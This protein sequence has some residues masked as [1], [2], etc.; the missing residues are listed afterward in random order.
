MDFESVLKSIK[1]SFSPRKTIDFDEEDI[2]VDIEPLTSKEETIVLESCKDVDDME[3]IETLKRHTLACAIKKINDLDIDTD[4]I[5]YEEGKSKSKFLY[6]IDYLAR[7][8]STVIDVLFE[9][10]THMQKDIEQRVKATAKYERILLSEIVPVEEEEKGE[11]R[12]TVENTSEGLTEV[13][14]LKEQ[15]DKEQQDE[16]VRM[17]DSEETAREKV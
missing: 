8:P 9:A 4:E 16:E 11:F 15:V 7:W 6:M 10:F 3:Y 14:K 17:S 5:E 1:K 12:R 2:H 13:E